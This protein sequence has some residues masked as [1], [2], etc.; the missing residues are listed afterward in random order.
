MDAMTLV[1]LIIATLA[2]L[3]LTMLCIGSHLLNRTTED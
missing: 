2:L 1:L 3:A